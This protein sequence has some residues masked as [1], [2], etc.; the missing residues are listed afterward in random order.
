MVFIVFLLSRFHLVFLPTTLTSLLPGVMLLNRSTTLRDSATNF[1]K[2]SQK[3]MPERERPNRSVVIKNN[4]KGHKSTLFFVLWTQL[5]TKSN[6]ILI[7]G[8][9]LDALTI[10]PIKVSKHSGLR[11]IWNVF[12]V[13]CKMWF[14][15]LMPFLHMSHIWYCV[16]EGSWMPYWGNKNFKKFQKGWDVKRYFYYKIWFLWLMMPLLS[17]SNLIVISKEM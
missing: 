14:L 12:Y 10:E 9:V 4:Q 1:E 13:T 11:E 5:W 15:W 7:W 2:T 6:L 17:E 8:K 3:G 16:Q